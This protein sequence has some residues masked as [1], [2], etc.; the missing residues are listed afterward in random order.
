MSQNRVETLTLVPICPTNR[1]LLPFYKLFLHSFGI[2]CVD[3]VNRGNQV[4]DVLFPKLILVWFMD[5]ISFV[6]LGKDRSFMSDLGK[7][8]HN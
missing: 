6:S 2:R 5:A 8:S 3:G 4:L 7:G 1:L